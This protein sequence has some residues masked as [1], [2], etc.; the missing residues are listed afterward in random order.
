MKMEQRK[1][2]QC[3]GEND[4]KEQEREIQADFS[5]KSI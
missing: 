1:M 5:L 2:R 4:I 3:E